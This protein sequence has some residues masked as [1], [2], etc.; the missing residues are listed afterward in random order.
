MADTRVEQPDHSR[1]RERQ[2]NDSEQ[3]AAGKSRHIGLRVA[4]RFSLPARIVILIDDKLHEGLL[5]SDNLSGAE[6]F[7]GSSNFMKQSRN[8]P[9][10]RRLLED[11][12]ATARRIH[13][14]HVQYRHRDDIRCDVNCWIISSCTAAK[15]P[16]I[17]VDARS[18]RAQ[19]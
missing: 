1:E 8:K 13:S 5:F 10:F 12:T 2:N 9:A 15:R 16:G 6:P 14:F 18:N 4:V 3:D 19:H 17:Y 7:H 11:G